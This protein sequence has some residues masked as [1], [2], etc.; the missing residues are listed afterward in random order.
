MIYTQFYNGL[1]VIN[2]EIYSKFDLSN[3][4]VTFG[5]DI[6]ND[7]NVTTIPKLSSAQAAQAALTNISEDY[8]NPFS[9]R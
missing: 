1:E 8:N 7:I 9:K 5:L 3:Q 4:L 6:F 2:S